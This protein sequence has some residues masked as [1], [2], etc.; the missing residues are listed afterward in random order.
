MQ[1]SHM[2]IPQSFQKKNFQQVLGWVHSSSPP[3]RPHVDPS[4]MA[5]LVRV[6]HNI[7]RPEVSSS[8]NIWS[9]EMNYH[10]Y[11]CQRSMLSAFIF[12]LHICTFICGSPKKIKAVQ[13]S[14]FLLLWLLLEG[15][16]GVSKKTHATP[17]EYPGS[18]QLKCAEVHTVVSNTSTSAL[19]N[20]L[21]HCHPIRW[22][23]SEDWSCC[24]IIHLC[25]QGNVRSALRN[26]FSFSSP[27]MNLSE[28]DVKW[29][30]LH[31]S[32]WQCLQ[33]VWQ[34]QFHLEY[35]FREKRWS[36]QKE[37]HC[38]SVTEMSLARLLLAG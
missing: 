38:G 35:V 7:I 36:S 25:L 9:I 24:T 30:M 32:S 26:L 10:C 31:R 34:W 12:K 14:F 8:I 13:T 33:N 6:Q 1:I 5:R 17:L 18:S 3:A 23:A 4:L 15:F 27:S 29:A 28:Q 2:D 37:G 22:H 11:F 19:L 20:T 16:A 21:S